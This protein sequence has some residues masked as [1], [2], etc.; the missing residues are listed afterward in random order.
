M[1]IQT[2]FT[3]PVLFLRIVLIV[4]VSVTLHELAHGWVAVSQGDDSPKRDGRLTLNPVVHMGWESIIFLC[5]AGIAWGKMPIEP[6]RFRH[7]KISR[8]LVAVAGPLLNLVL[9][10][11]FLVLLKWNF[12][13]SG[14]ILSGKFLHLVAYINLA[15]FLFNLLPIP[16]LDGFH[17][18]SELF[19]ELKSLEGTPFGLFALAILF[20]TGFSSGLRMLVNGVICTFIS[21][22]QSC[23]SL[24]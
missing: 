11:L 15:L 16:P 3:D 20:T 9:G 12:N 22:L 21:S 8:I 19:P 10:L 6:W 2:F 1:L 5:L 4:I 18:C 24:F 14:T 7:Q 23:S 13:L 17:I